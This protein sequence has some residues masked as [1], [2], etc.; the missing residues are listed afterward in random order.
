MKTVEGSLVI[1]TLVSE[2]DYL[3]EGFCLVNELEVCF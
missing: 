1:Y 3:R 2:W